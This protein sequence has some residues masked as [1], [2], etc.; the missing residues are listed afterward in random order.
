M[1]SSFLK[2]AEKPF[3]TWGVTSLSVIISLISRCRSWFIGI[4]LHFVVIQLPSQ[5]SPWRV[6]DLNQDTCPILPLEDLLNKIHVV[7]ALFRCHL[8]I[9]AADMVVAVHS[10]QR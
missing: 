3:Y 8:A 7:L 4:L 9:N 2:M 6:V 5:P 10:I 1:Y